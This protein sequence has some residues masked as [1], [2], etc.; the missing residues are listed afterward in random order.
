MDLVNICRDLTGV[1]DACT[2]PDSFDVFFNTLYPQFFATLKKAITAHAANSRVT[3]NILSLLLATV[4]NRN[5]RVVYDS[6]N[7]IG[8]LLFKVAAEII[9]IFGGVLLDR[10][11]QFVNCPEHVYDGIT[12]I[13]QI[14][15]R[16]IS[17]WSAGAV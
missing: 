15:H 10:F 6:A 1:V 8:I 13:F 2:S 14:M 12:Y 7:G 9:C 11:P 16:L 4:K 5:F 17:E 3:S